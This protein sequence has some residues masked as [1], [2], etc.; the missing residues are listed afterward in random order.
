MRF[1]GSKIRNFAAAKTPT[2]VQDIAYITGGGRFR[3]LNFGEEL[4]ENPEQ[5][6][7]VFTPEHLRNERAS[8][9]QELGREL[10]GLEHQFGL[11]ESVLYPGSSD[12]GRTVVKYRICLPGFQML[13][14]QVSSEA[15]ITPL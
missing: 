1:E 15:C 5:A 11:G 9:D 6:V 10:H 13:Y 12:V 4:I 7:V 2:L 8:F 3:S 14:L